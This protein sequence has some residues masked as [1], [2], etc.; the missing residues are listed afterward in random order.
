VSSSVDRTAPERASSDT[1]LREIVARVVGQAAAGEQVEAVAAR[2]GG[3]GV[4]AYRGE[5]ESLTSAETGAIGIR[6]IRD[7]RTGFAH[8]GSLEPAVIAEVLAEAR[9]NVAFAQPDLDQALAEPDGVAPIPQPQSWNESILRDPVDAK[10]ERAIRLERLTIGADPRVTSVR[11]ASYSDSWG[12]SALASTTG[13]E[14]YSR[15]TWCSASVSAMATAGDETQMGYGYDVARDPSDLDLDRAAAEA[16]ERSTRLLGAVK[17]NSARLAIVCEPRITATLMSIVAGMCSGEAVVKGRSPFIGRMGET[18]GSELLSLYDDPTDP[19]SFGAEEFDGEGLACRRN[20]LIDGGTLSGYLHNSYTARRMG[21]ASTAS[22]VRGAR[23]LPG[24]GAMALMLRAG[25]G[26]LEQLIS[27]VEFGLL[28]NS[29]AGLHSGVNPVSGDFSVGADGILIR[30][31]ELAEPVRELTLAST[32]QRMLGG[33]THVGDDLE[34]LPGG[35]T[36]PSIV[37]ADL[38]ASGR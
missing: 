3:V 21:T 10:V 17:P 29:F 6:V 31:G 1:D 15:G 4:K 16:V 36:M 34:A 25:S 12:E 35:S 28:V 5:V 20:P 7:G 38:A 18:V 19:N 22:A 32:I 24:V 26:D 23:S 27:G 37:I 2:S 8:A 14:A 33:V 30:N 11:T 9:D 13:M